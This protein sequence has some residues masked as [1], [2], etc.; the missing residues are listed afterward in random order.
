MAHLRQVEVVE[1]LWPLLLA[2]LVGVAV[3]AGLARWW[4]R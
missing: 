2:L 3:A 1:V 4:G